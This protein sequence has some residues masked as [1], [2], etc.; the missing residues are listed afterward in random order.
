[1]PASP[2]RGVSPNPVHSEEETQVSDGA[3][4]RTWTLPPPGDN[5]MVPLFLTVLSEKARKN[6]LNKTESL[7]T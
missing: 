5:E 7:T 2:A 4:Y 1:M 6:R 3:K